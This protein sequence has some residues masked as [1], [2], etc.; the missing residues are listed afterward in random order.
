[1]SDEKK[2]SWLQR[3]RGWLNGLDQR[4]RRRYRLVQ[5]VAAVCAVIVLL[6]AVYGAFVRRPSIPQL[7]ADV[8]VS[9][10]ATQLNTGPRRSGVYTFLVVGK[11]TGGGGNTDTMILVTYDT[12]GKTINAMSLPRD[13]MANVSWN[14]KKLNTVYNYYKGKDKATQTEN[15]MTALKVHVGKLTGILPDFYVMV[16]WDAVGELVDAIGG[17][18]F[19]VPYDMHYDDPYQDLHIHQDKGERKLSGEDAM[20]VIRWRKN[21]GKY[22]N[23]QIGDAGRMKIQQDFLVAVAKECLQFKHLMNA[24]EFARIFTENVDTDLTVGNLAWFGQQ[25]IGMNAQED[26]RFC[27]MPY[28]PYTRNTAYVL[29]VVDELLAVLNNGLN[30]YKEEITADDLE[31]LQLN[32]DGSMSLTSGTLA[33]S[34][35]AKPRKQAQPKPQQPVVPES[36]GQE[37][38]EAPEAQ[39]EQSGT[40]EPPTQETQPEQPVEPTPEPQPEETEPGPEKTDEETTQ[41]TQEPVVVLP[42]TPVPVQ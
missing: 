30:P 13:T 35:L 37:A 27:T 4:Q 38:V 10:G 8:G 42:A 1:M 19:D 32:K 34:A 39:P 26:I 5:V 29:P 11:D 14:N 23:F 18:N 16:E 28:T 3:Y 20:Q 2:R 21:N 25:A 15:G 9:A 7:P 41:T 36:S 24:S 17:V 6:L 22:G 33:D 31:V 12:S 40:Q